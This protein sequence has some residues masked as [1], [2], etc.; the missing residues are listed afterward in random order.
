MVSREA[1]PTEENWSLS[2]Y[3][4]E[5]EVQHA[6]GDKELPLGTPVGIGPNQLDVWKTAST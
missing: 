3:M 1:S 2:T 5:R 4:T 6:F